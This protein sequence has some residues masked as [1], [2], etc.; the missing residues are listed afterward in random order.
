MSQDKQENGVDNKTS[1]VKNS[2]RKNKR[3]VLDEE[4]NRWVNF[5]IDGEALQAKSIGIGGTKTV[6]DMGN[7]YVVG[8]V[9][10]GFTNDSPDTYVD[11]E[12][13]I[14]KRLQSLGLRAL[15]YEKIYIQY[16]DNNTPIAALKMPSFQMM[17]INGKQVRDKKNPE[18]SCGESMLFGNLT[19]LQSTDHWRK[20]L[21]YIAGD[22]SI[23][24]VN[25]FNFTDDSFNL[26]IEDTEKSA[27]IKSTSESRI[28][29]DLEQNIH[30]FFF[31]FS[32]FGRLYK[33]DNYY[34]FKDQH[35]VIQEK[36]ISDAV[37]NI[38]NR[39]LNTILMSV[40]D[41]EYQLI[42]VGMESNYFDISKLM[43]ESD[44]ASGIAWKELVAQVIVE[45]KTLLNEEIKK[46]QASHFE[47]QPKVT[48]C[49]SG[50]FNNGGCSGS[51]QYRDS[52]GNCYSISSGNDCRNSNSSQCESSLK[53]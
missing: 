37:N 10:K 33:D 51:K 41:D 13:N 7:G 47:I 2:A 50:F 14:S 19:N 4:G 27:V 29:S 43:K 24:L 16:I 31:D 22:I 1:L 34:H 28:F 8:L 6:V 17:A 11:N 5:Y 18:S 20:L 9:T 21:K 35:D 53:F 44:T 12:V 52:F 23:Y 48:R 32:D 25:N 45:V 36:N 40:S 49:T 42:M 39:V 46:D 30:L 3:W 26:L 38:R 15:E